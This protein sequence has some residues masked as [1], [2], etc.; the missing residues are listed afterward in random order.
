MKLNNKAA[1]IVC[2]LFGFMFK[3]NQPPKLSIK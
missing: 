1:I 2:Y 3:D